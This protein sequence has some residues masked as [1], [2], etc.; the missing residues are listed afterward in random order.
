MLN[1]LLGALMVLGTVVAMVLTVLAVIVGVV[2]IAAAI[3]KVIEVVKGNDQ[4]KNGG[5]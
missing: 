4:R 2:I 3:S 1:V 5:R